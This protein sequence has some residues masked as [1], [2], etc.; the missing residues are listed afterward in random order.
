MGHMRDATDPPLATHS[1][2]L[3]SLMKARPGAAILAFHRVADL[4]AIAIGWRIICRL[5]H[6]CFCSERPLPISRW[7]WAIC[8]TRRI[9]EEN[10]QGTARSSVIGVEASSVEETG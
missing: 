4:F 8:L 3:V 10:G 5:F 2:P 7:V 1:A 6:P 9:P